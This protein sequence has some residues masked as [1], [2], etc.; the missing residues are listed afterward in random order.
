MIAR[1]TSR[2]YSGFIFRVAMKAT[3]AAGSS[4]SRRA[5]RNGSLPEPGGSGQFSV[6]PTAAPVP[7]ASRLP[8]PVSLPL[9]VLQM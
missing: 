4:S 2:Q 9:A 7:V 3:S 8:V 1:M 5:A 6:R